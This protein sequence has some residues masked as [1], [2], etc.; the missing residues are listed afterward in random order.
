MYLYAERCDDDL[1]EIIISKER[2]FELIQS[3]DNLMIFH[4]A[5][6]WDFGDTIIDNA[7]CMVV[8]KYHN[9]TPPEFFLAYSREI[10]NNTKK[11]REQTGRLIDK[12]KFDWYACDSKYNQMDLVENYGIKFHRSCVIPPLHRVD[13][14]SL[15]VSK[16]AFQ[17]EKDT[18]H[19]LFV[20]RFAPNKGH[21]HLVQSMYEY[22][23]MYDDNIVLNIVGSVSDSL[24][25]YFDEINEMIGRYGL[26]DNIVIHNYVSFEELYSF[27]KSSDVFLLMSE[28]EGFCIPIIESQFTGL[29][30]IALNTSVIS[31]TM[32]EGQIII[33]ELDYGLFAGAIRRVSTDK[34]L[35]DALIRDGIDN[36]RNYENDRIGQ[37]WMEVIDLIFNRKQIL[38]Q[39]KNEVSL[40]QRT[41]GNLDRSLIRDPFPRTSHNAGPLKII[42]VSN[43]YP[44][45]FL[46]GA[47]VIAHYQAKAMKNLGHDIIVFA[48]D[49][50][51]PG[52]LHTMRQNRYDDLDVYRV[53]LENEDYSAHYFN[54]SHKDIEAH[55][56]QLLDAFHPDIVHIHNIM[57]LSLG[58]IHLSRKKG[59]KTFITLHDNWG[60]CC[61]NTILKKDSQICVTFDGCESCLRH[62]DDGEERRIPISMRKDYLMFQLNEADG[63][64]SPS[65]YIADNYIRA[66]FPREKL[67]VIW[68]G[69][70]IEKYS[71]V[72]KQKS[73]VI[74]F[75]YIGYLGIHKGIQVLIDTLP[76]FK[77]VPVRINLV[78]EGDQRRD[79]E[80]KIRR[81]GKE[82]SVKFWGK[83]ENR[84]ID[85]VLSD[86]D[87][88]VLP[89]IWP[90][91]QPVTITEAMASKIPVIASDLGGI[92][93]LIDDGVS[94]L[95]CK[96]G[97]VKDLFDRMMYFILNPEKIG[98]F[99]LS[100]Y[101]KVINKT[102]QCQAEEIIDLYNNVSPI[103]SS[104]EEAF[105]VCV[106]KKM[107]NQ[108]TEAISLIKKDSD[109]C[110]NRIRFVL[111][112]WIDHDQIQ[113]AEI[114][115]VV[116]EHLN[117]D[118]VALL[119]GVNVPL[120]I[121]ERNKNLTRYCS[122]HNCGL[123]F[124][125]TVEA[126][127]CIKYL[128]KNKNIATVIG[129]NFNKNHKAVSL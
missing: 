28:H 60:F 124:K 29:P 39:E 118:A 45:N 102:F 123:Y 88:F 93:E 106:G 94:G 54:F 127:E 120:V 27:Y 126:Y 83:V 104:R 87:V 55:F 101:Y 82:Q 66:G 33:D 69:I 105:I 41:H 78:G 57:G 48:G 7:R 30:V 24:R 5:Y 59:I 16:P 113:K 42:I 21:K 84:D 8:M 90:E 74:R 43:R 71:F 116:D 81:Y 15:V 51:V 122:I 40:E 117:E 20:G 34:N 61:I 96:P 22:T 6:F 10:F 70:D 19:V 37:Q 47:E 89:S 108:C 99:G 46:G 3:K 121:P 62:I 77:E 63:F 12:G 72:N 95:L 52:P 32:G 125:D 111:N 64:I 2:L 107:M 85:K 53:A 26:T 9:I 86:T 35:R 67:N 13:D 114:I 65:R 73:E 11:G 110:L 75:T 23:R 119:Q 109:P 80:K 38:P 25:S 92:P 44:P 98:E 103:V 1:R 100:A 50:Q 49:T 68:N 97:D 17:N 129:N 56:D 76:L 18:V 36:Y 115:W 4:H 79:L 31:D 112:E 14:F 128:L 91:N 58:I